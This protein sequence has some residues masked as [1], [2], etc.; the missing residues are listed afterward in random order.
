MSIMYYIY[1]HSIY[2]NTYWLYINIGKHFETNHDCLPI[3]PPS[4]KKLLFF[5][6]HINIIKKKL[7]EETKGSLYIP[8]SSWI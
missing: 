4:R 5:I 3:R 1:K 7:T 6:L 8:S 2:V